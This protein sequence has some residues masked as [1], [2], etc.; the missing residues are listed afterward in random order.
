MGSKDYF[1]EITGKGFDDWTRTKKFPK[2]DESVSEIFKTSRTKYKRRTLGIAE[3]GTPLRISEE[4]R[5]SHM[6]IIGT[7][8]EGKSKLLEYLIRE[9][10]D[11]GNGLCFFDPSENGDTLYKILAYCEQKGRDKVLLVDPHHRYRFKK[12]APINPFTKYREDSVA[13]VMDTI[14]VLFRQKDASETPIIQ[15]YLPAILNVLHTAGMTLS[16]TLYFT[17][18]LYVNQREQILDASDPHS[19]QRLMLE[20]VFGNRQLYMEFQSTI[21]RLEPLFHPT[22]Q[23]IF[24]STK[25]IDFNQLIAD[26]WVILVNLYAGFGFEPI[27]TRLLGTAII[28]EIISSL[29]SLSRLKFRDKL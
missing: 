4:E 5:E 7:T 23:L 19:R 20:Q 10:I 18:P 27:H 16:D 26:G 2:V 12:I 9:D 1:K 17:D 21:R 8:G 22:L 13:N 15:R 6:H 14:R 28:N 29:D 25:G 24:G 11:R 3:D